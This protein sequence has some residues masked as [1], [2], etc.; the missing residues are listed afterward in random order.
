MMAQMPIRYSG[1]AIL[2]WI[3]LIVPR[4]GYAQ[5]GSDRFAPVPI[6][7]FLY[8]LD[9]HVLGSFTYSYGIFHLAA[10][11]PTYALVKTGGDWKW[12][13]Y[14]NDH[15]LS[16]DYSAAVVGAIVP[17]V[18]PV[19]L[20]LYGWSAESRDLQI[21]GLALGQAALLGAGIASTYKALTGRRPPNHPDTSPTEPDYSADFHFG[22]LR[23]GAYSGWPSSHTTIA[24]AMATTVTELY[25]ENT[26]LA[27]ISY[28]YASFIGI[29]VSWNIHWL[30]DVVAGALIGYSVGKTVGSG[31]RG[32]RDRESGSSHLSFS[33]LPNGIRVCCT[34]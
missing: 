12:Y 29:G 31:F 23:R 30:S 10:I 25:P 4:P 15:G 27:V 24:F 5:E 14:A 3:L 6:S 8:H 34:F 11:P 17:F 2:L 21:T 26:L 13:T 20:Y 18:A 9:R 22:F 1:I 7:D 16:K 33:I 32:L 19:A 28:A